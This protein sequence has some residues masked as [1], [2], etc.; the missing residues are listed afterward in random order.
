MK[1]NMLLKLIA[2]IAILSSSAF[3]DSPGFL[4][5]FKTVFDDMMQ[6]TVLGIIVFIMALITGITAFVTQRWGVL[7][8]GV[9]G[10]LIVVASPYIGGPDL[11]QWASDTFG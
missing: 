9:V 1:K 6:D 3:A 11:S 5:S 7:I 8:W 4:E 2:L 10:I